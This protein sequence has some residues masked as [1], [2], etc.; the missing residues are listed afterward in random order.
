MARLASRCVE[1]RSSRAVYEPAAKPVG[2]PLQ[3]GVGL[4]FMSVSAW[5]MKTPALMSRTHVGAARR[6]HSPHAWRR[7]TRSP[8]TPRGEREYDDE[9][10][11][12]TRPTTPTT[13]E[14]RVTLARVRVLRRQE[15]EAE[16]RRRRTPTSSQEERIA[17]DAGGER[18]VRGG[19][20]RGTPLPP[21]QQARTN[22]THPTQNHPRTR[23]HH[24]VTSKARVRTT[25]HN[26]TPNHM[27]IGCD[28]PRHTTPHHRTGIPQ[29]ANTTAH[30]AQSH[31]HRRETIP[32]NHYHHDEATDDGDGRWRR[33]YGYFCG[34][35]PTQTRL[36]TADCDHNPTG[37]PTMDGT[38]SNP[39]LGRREG[40]EGTKYQGTINERGRSKI[41]KR[42]K[43]TKKS[44]IKERWT[45]HKKTKRKNKQ[46]KEKQADMATKTAAKEYRGDEQRGRV[47]GKGNNKA[48]GRGK[49]EGKGVQQGGM[50]KGREKGGRTKGGSGKGRP[51][52]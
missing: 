28:T 40:T 25:H 52:A 8:R 36:T 31:H 7:Q 23:T 44:K 16:E 48:K 4:C 10:A 2:I 35:L 1:Q 43:R 50:T 17:P 32:R 38:S 22:H 9:A 13:E 47:E 33:R 42:T 19:S 34:S 18:R 20:V 14:D 5:V 30:R 51:G 26:T 37:N 46:Q 45:D 41:G 49:T 11:R 12:A 27:Q 29:H 15:A 3:R 24:F 21:I 39:P 6:G